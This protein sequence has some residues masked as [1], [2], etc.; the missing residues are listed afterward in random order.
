M[1]AAQFT[2][3]GRDATLPDS[4]RSVRSLLLKEKGT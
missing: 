4:Q 3:T 1:R 2:I